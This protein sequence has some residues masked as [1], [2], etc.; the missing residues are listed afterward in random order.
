MTMF[1]SNREKEQEGAQG[2]E[3]ENEN[4]RKFLESFESRM[5][6]DED[7]LILFKRPI[8]SFIP[9]FLT[10]IFI[11]SFPL[12]LL[13]DWNTRPATIMWEDV[14]KL[15]FPLF[16]AFIIFIGNQR[17]L[18]Q[19]YFFKRKIKIFFSINILLV[20]ALLFIRE[21]FFYFFDVGPN[22]GSMYALYT[23]MPGN[24]RIGEIILFCI[25]FLLFILIIC[26]LNI[27][28]RV[29]ANHSNFAYW[30]RWKQSMILK[31]DL[32]FLK[33]QLSPHFLFNTL[34]NIIALMDVDVKKAQAGLIQLS[35]LLRTILYQSKEDSIP[36]KAD[37]DML[38]KYL[39]LERLRFGENVDCQ[40]EYTI[41]EPNKKIVPLLLLPLIENTMK[42]GVHPEKPSFIHIQ[43]TEAAGKLN[44]II[45]NTS[46]PRPKDPGKPGGIGLVN[47]QK[48]LDAFYRDR[49]VY[50]HAEADG[51]YKV[52]LEVTL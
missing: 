10:W 49:Y 43:I 48:R 17:F 1:C 37:I 29:T 20:F 51:K 27:T 41:A 38:D 45:E 24:H 9:I 33:L 7:H 52:A 40:F 35:A 2:F 26:F 18:I 46:Y 23:A 30:L 19:K 28:I 42:H 31:S 13:I 50:T 36:L 15:Y 22:S 4:V 16:A 3:A 32:A 34:N 39:K 8:P 6:G 47:M 21:L 11:L 12:L 5:K 44:C 25:S 14:A